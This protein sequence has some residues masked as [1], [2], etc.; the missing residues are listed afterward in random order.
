MTK[1][2]ATERQVEIIFFLTWGLFFASLFFIGHTIIQVD[3]LREEINNTQIERDLLQEE[4][5]SMPHYNCWNE[6]ITETLEIEPYTPSYLFLSWRSG[7]NCVDD[8]YDEIIC[9]EGIK[10]YSCDGKINNYNDVNGTCIAKTTKEVC[11][12]VR[13][14]EGVRK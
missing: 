14:S 6:T 5:D 9:E 7:Y 11:E 4:I 13:P 2:Y 3:E 12:I 1:K 10:A 8:W